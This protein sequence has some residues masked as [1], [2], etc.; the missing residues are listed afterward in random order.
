[1]PVISHNIYMDEPDL[2]QEIFYISDQREIPKERSLLLED[3]KS[4]FLIETVIFETFFTIHYGKWAK[5]LLQNRLL[6]ISFRRFFGSSTGD[7]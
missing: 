4:L 1:M 5:S 2:T 6:S 7:K 3:M